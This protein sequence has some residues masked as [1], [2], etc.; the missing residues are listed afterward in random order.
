M[1]I[2]LNDK[3]FNDVENKIYKKYRILK[4]SIR[5]ARYKAFHDTIK[6]FKNHKNY[7]L[8]HHYINEN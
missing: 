8:V 5:E 4:Y 3:I 6:Y 2:S 1:I 7:T